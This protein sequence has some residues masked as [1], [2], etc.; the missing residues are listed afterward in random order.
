ME[1]WLTVKKGSL[2]LP[3][4]TYSPD[5]CISLWCKNITNKTH[6]H[7]WQISLLIPVTDPL[8]TP[9]QWKNVQL[10]FVF[11]FAVTYSSY[12]FYF[13]FLPVQHLP[14]NQVILGKEYH[15]ML[16]KKITNKNIKSEKVCSSVIQQFVQFYKHCHINYSNNSR[17]TMVTTASRKVFPKL[18]KLSS[19]GCKLKGY[20]LH[21]C[22]Y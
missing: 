12:K 6:G 20:Y 16:K 13:N 14:G 2:W 1:K 17:G 19:H 11:V 10:F 18:F 8:K 15:T 5:P 22:P 21:I 7:V 9:F 4:Y 3:Q